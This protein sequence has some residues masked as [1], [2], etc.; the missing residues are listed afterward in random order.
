LVVLT[1]TSAWPFT[2][3]LYTSPR[4][5]IEGTRIAFVAP[6]GTIPARKSWIASAPPASPTPSPDPPMPCS[7]RAPQV[8]TIGGSYSDFR[9]TA[10]FDDTMGHLCLM[11]PSTVREAP[12]VYA[13][14]ADGEETIND[15]TWAQG[16]FVDGVPDVLVLR[17]GTG[18]DSEN[19]FIRKYVPAPAH[20]FL[21]FR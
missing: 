18:G 2:I 7:M 1:S 16:I 8:Y 9:P 3:S 5:P 12:V 11:L 17:D 19:V 6:N 4:A 14:H 10:A 13:V 15:H 20:R 21:F